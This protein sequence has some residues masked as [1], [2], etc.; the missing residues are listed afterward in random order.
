VPKVEVTAEIDKQADH[1]SDYAIMFSNWVNRGYKNRE[2]LD[3]RL[4]RQTIDNITEE[5]EQLRK[6]FEVSE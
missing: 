3:A 5:L 6:H 2:T 1:M 4:M